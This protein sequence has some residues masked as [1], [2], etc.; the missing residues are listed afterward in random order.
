MLNATIHRHAYAS[1][2][3]PADDGIALRVLGDLEVGLF[4]PDHPEQRG[5]KFDLVKACLRRYQA[6]TG[7]SDTALNVYS[8]TEAPPGSGLGSSSALVVATLAALWHWR[9]LPLDRYELAQ[10][11]WQ[12]ERHDAGVPGGLQDQYASSFGGFNFI[13]FHSSTDVVVNPLKIDPLIVRELEYNLLLVFTGTTRVSAGI[14]DSQIRNYVDHNRGVEAAMS[15]MKALAIEAKKALLKGQLDDLGRIL[16]EEWQ[17]KKRTAPLVSTKRIDELYSYA[18]AA[19]AI[20]GKVSGAGGGGYMFL[21]CPFD[22]RATVSK[23]LSEAGC[24]VSAVA[25]EFEGIQTWERYTDPVASA[26]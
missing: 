17:E 11:A 23:R 6:E 22:K 18:L 16:H 21:Y 10:L 4:H 12:V 3:L 20:G 5:G 14:I 19:G 2:R 1:L 8:E 24:T 13:E 26:T 7:S 15:Q 25:F 9:R